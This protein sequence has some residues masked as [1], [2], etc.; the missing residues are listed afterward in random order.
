ML[1]KWSEASGLFWLPIF[2]SF[3]AQT[4][5]IN[6]FDILNFKVQNWEHKIITL[7]SL[8]I[9]WKRERQI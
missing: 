5:N 9:K 3:W 6:M 7:K 8:E 4:E 2:V 1:K